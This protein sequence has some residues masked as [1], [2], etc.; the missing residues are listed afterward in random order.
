VA[1]GFGVE[2]AGWSTRGTAAGEAVPG[3]AATREMRVRRRVMGW[4][5]CMV[6]VCSR[7]DV[8]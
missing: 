2:P 4:K 1:S 5:N 7:M 3:A 8:C 6:A